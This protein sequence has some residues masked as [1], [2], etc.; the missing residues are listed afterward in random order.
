[1][2]DLNEHVGETPV[3]QAVSRFERVL[4]AAPPLFDITQPELMEHGR[5]TG[6]VLR[7]RLSGT[8]PN[9]RFDTGWIS[10]QLLLGQA[11]AELERAISH[12]SPDALAEGDYGHH[13]EALSRIALRS[14]MTYDP[15]ALLVS[16]QT[17]ARSAQATVAA[18]APPPAAWGYCC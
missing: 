6:R 16:A 7:E 13:L 3:S 11:T 5:A 8:W 10:A 17:I 15:D 1:M 2:T 12:S 18:V 14:S 4:M 9:T